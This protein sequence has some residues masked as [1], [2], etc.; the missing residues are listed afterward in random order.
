MELTK[1]Y[2]F[3]GF[4]LRLGRVRAG[5]EDDRARLGTGCLTLHGVRQSDCC[6]Y[7]SCRAQGRT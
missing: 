5:S 1:P 2:T 4:D 6:A 3:M 7:G